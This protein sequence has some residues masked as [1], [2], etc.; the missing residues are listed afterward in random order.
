MS[1]ITDD[2]NTTSSLNP[3]HILG[4]ER[5]LDLQDVRNL[6]SVGEVTA[7]KIMKEAGCIT[8]HR[9]LY[10]FESQMTAYLKSIQEVPYAS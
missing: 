3:S 2:C 4:N 8:L 5:L 6:L 10:C 1:T 7:S 9:R